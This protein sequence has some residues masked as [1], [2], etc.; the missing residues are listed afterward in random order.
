MHALPAVTRHREL[1]H[2]RRPTLPHRG[3]A[4]SVQFGPRIPRLDSPALM[5]SGSSLDADV[6]FMWVMPARRSTPDLE[7]R[8]P[9]DGA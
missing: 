2:H 6:V 4:K 3:S 1:T 5:S 9:A 7:A 8:M